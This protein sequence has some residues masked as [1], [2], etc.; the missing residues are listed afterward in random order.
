MKEVP[1]AS[2]DITAPLKMQIINLEYDN[3]L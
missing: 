1:E 2:D 3:F